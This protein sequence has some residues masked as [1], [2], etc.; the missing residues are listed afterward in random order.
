[1]TD[2]VNISPGHTNV[3]ISTAQTFKNAMVDWVE[4]GNNELIAGYYG[5]LA[6][7]PYNSFNVAATDTGG[8][9]PDATIDTGEAQVGGATL[10]RD[11]QTVVD[12]LDNTSNQDVFLGWAYNAQDTVK[13]GRSGA[14][15][16]DDERRLIWTF[17]TSGGSVTGQTDHRPLTKLVNL[18]NRRYETSDGSGTAVD[19]AA[20]ATS[21]DDATTLNNRLLIDVTRNSQTIPLPLGTIRPGEY[22]QQRL[23]RPNSSLSAKLLFHSN[24][25][26]ANNAPTGQEVVIVAGNGDELYR[27]NDEVAAGIPDNP[28]AGPWDRIY[29]EF[30][31]ENNTGGDIRAGAQFEILFE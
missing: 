7:G 19:Q 5:N 10:A 24:L 3:S 26:V 30:R 29:L 20:N 2:R 9:P 8:S 11:T 23:T 27:S 28:L 16:A 17:D 1:M 18:E 13:I 25:D 4:P 31:L 22:A 6:A 12:L 21:A 15:N 14:F